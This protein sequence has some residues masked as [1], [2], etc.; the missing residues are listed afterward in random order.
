MRPSERALALVQGA[1]DLHVHVEPDILPRKTDDLTLAWRFRELGLRGFLLKS[2]YAPTAERA[3]V[4]RKAVPGVEVLGAVVLN[5]AVGGLNPLAVEVAARAGARFVW[6]PTVDAANEAGEV[7]GLPAEKRPQWARLQGEFA[8]QGLLP[9]PIAVLDGTGRVRPEVR[10]VLRVVARHGLVLA[11]G[12][13]SREEVLK[14]V[15][16][17]LE[18]GVRQV[19]VTHPDYPTQ[20]LSIE[21]QRYLAGQ[22]AYLERCLA[23]SWTGKVPWERLFAAIRRAGVEQSF[24]ST[25]LGQP[26]NPPV[27]EGLALFADRL[28]EAG[29]SEAEVRHMAVEVPS[30]LARG[31][32]G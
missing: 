22:G 30:L 14:V 25:D 23:P 13:L 9:P 11:T 20:N 21:E 8:G 7:E 19:V 2:H 17:A 1:Y 15:E 16:A 29:F 18:E 27:E 32:G 6:M 12:H 3:Q 31:G 10:A 24:L 5:H 28:L 4:V 26:K